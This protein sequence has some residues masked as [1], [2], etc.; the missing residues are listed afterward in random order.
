M[1]DIKQT[2]AAAARRG[3][4]TTSQ[5]EQ[6]H[7]FVD[8]HNALPRSAWDER[9]WRRRVALLVRLGVDRGR[10]GGTPWAGPAVA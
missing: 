6:L 3:D 8:L 7:G 1:D 2:I 4:V 10:F 9:T 5:A